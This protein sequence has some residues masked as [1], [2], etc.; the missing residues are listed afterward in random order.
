MAAS[1]KERLEKEVRTYSE[2]NNLTVKTIDFLYAGPHMRG[3]HSLILA[4]TEAGIFTFVFKLSDAE[5]HFLDGKTVQQIAL[6]KKTLVYRLYIRAV[7]EEGELEEGK[8]LV[9][10]RVLGRKWHKETLEKLINK[11]LP[12]LT[13]TK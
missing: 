4:F 13:A 3:R 8:Y 9:S 2:D 10:K 7:T 6:E 12:L 11:N 1:L 5:M